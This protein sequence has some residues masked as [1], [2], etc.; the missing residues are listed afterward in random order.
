MYG[1]LGRIKDSLDWF[2]KMK[3]E[4]TKPSVMTYNAIIDMYSKMQLPEEAI[5][6]FNTMENNGVKPNVR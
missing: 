2:Q 5:N 3:I 6:V 1:K 4:N